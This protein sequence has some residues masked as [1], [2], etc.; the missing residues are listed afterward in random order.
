ML[1]T[2]IIGVILNATGF[3]GMSTLPET[4]FEQNFTMNGIG[5]FTQGFGDLFANPFNAFVVIFSLLF[6]DFFDTAETLVAVGSRIGLIIDKGDLENC[7]RA[8]LADS[9]GTVVGAALGT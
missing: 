5:A 9:I 8:L 3:A 6:V 2:A 1:F 7:E 4:I